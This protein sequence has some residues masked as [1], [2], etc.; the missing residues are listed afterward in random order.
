MKRSFFRRRTKI[1]MPKP[2]SVP[3]VKEAAPSSLTRQHHR[4]AV[5]SYKPDIDNY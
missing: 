3:P 2:L 5:G 4:M 1:T